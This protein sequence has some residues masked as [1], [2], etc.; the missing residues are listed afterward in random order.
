MAPA[1]STKKVFHSSI[2]SSKI[3][4]FGFV[5]KQSST[6]NIGLCDKKDRRNDIMSLDRCDNAVSVSSFCFVLLVVTV[7]G[8]SDVAV[9]ICARQYDVQKLLMGKEFFF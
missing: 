7:V 6:D 4:K 1:M 9:P 3:R 2:R 8:G 5:T